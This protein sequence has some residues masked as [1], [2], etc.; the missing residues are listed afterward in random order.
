MRIFIALV[1]A[2]LSGVGM[3]YRLGFSNAVQRQINYAK[4]QWRP[5]DFE[6]QTANPATRPSPPKLPARDSPP[7]DP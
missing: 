4:P 7:T 1:I 6:D 3:G 5:S 2:T